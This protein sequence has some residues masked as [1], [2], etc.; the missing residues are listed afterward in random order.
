MATLTGKTIAST[1]KD[2][3]QISNS[4]SGI[5]GTKRAISDG[6]ATA[7]PLELSSTAVNI[8]SGFE[9]GDVAVTT[10]AT[11]LNY[12]TGLDQSLSTSSSPTFAQ[13]TVTG[14]TD[15][16]G[17]S[18]GQIQ[19]PAT[20]NASADAN[21]LDDYE[22]GGWTPTLYGATT[23]TYTTQFGRY[24]KIGNIVYF[25]GY[26]AINSLGDGSAAAMT[27]LP[28]AFPNTYDQSG[29]ISAASSLA[30]NVYSLTLRLVSNTSQIEVGGQTALDTTIGG[31]AVIGNGTV[32]SFSGTYRVN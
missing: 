21:T 25:Y 3:L 26:I 23:T 13:V 24:T 28:Y 16:S 5:D 30:I 6:E 10:S 32:L 1:Y 15:L 20:Q 4:N 12:L 29:I 19:F 7:S 9:I 27:G 14:L 8:S 2:L 17:A 22:E 18:A 31:L 11:E